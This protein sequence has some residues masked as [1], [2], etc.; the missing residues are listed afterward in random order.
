MATQAELQNKYE[1]F[2]LLDLLE[3]SVSFLPSIPPDT[4]Y[5]IQQLQPRRVYGEAVIWV[6]EAQ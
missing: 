4:S 5:I 6:N 1:I 3:M 2:K